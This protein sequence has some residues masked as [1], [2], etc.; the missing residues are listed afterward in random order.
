ML[1]KLIKNEFKSS[2]HSVANIYLAAGITIVIMML[3]Y[4]VKIKWISTLSTVALL[5]ISVI[6]VIITLVAVITNFYKTLYGQQGYLSFTLPVKSG[7]LLTAKALV[8]FV[9]ILVSYIITIAI[10][11]GVYIYAAKMVGKDTMTALKTMMQIFAGMPNADVIRKILII[12]C[13]MVFAQIAVF[14]AEVYFALTLANTKT[15]QKMG[16]ISAIFI[17]FAVFIVMQ[18][19][20]GTLTSVVPI[21]LVATV[22][23]LTVSFTQ[24]MMNSTG[25]LTLGITGF[26]FE[27]FAAAGLFAATAYLMK[28]KIN[29][30]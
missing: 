2:A 25:N 7:Q 4:V 28:N 11:V 15:F 26:I 21:S 27:V 5:L 16:T 1:G 18:I 29:V 19:L 20:V 23:G 24:S 6:A 22:D 13:V 3:S 12:F 9:W 30:K 14:I 8:S 10:W 17:F